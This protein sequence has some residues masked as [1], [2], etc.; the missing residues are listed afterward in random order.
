MHHVSKFRRGTC[1]VSFKK[2]KFAECQS[3]DVKIEPRWE[4]AGKEAV[5]AR[6]E[7]VPNCH[8]SQL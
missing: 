4:E 7:D 2:L 3:H 6:Q 1:S 5:I 8:F